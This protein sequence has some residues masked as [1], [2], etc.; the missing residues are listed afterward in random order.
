[1]VCKD[2]EYSEEMERRVDIADKL[3]YLREIK[4]IA[5]NYISDHKNKAM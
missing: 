2:P 1:M 5:S 4:E 3:R